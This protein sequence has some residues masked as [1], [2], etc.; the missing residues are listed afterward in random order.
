MNFATAFQRQR[1]SVIFVEGLLM[2][3]V[4]GFFD[5]MTTATK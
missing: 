4:T 3:L 2:V 5:A 1:P